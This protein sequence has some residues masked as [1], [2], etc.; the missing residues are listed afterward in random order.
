M[1][2]A[3]PEETLAE[4]YRWFARLEVHGKSPL[5]EELCEGVADDP[6]ML[7]FLA[8][9][10][11]AKRQPNL[12]LATARV[13]F[14]LASDYAG[15]RAAV[16]EHRD[17]VAAMLRTRRTQTN[18]PGRCA[19][20]LPLL[21]ELPQPL[22]LLEV[23]AAAG[24]CLLVDRYGYDYDGQRVGDDEVVF[25]CSVHGDVAVPRRLPEVVW[26]CGIDLEPI[27]LDDADAIG[28]LEALVWPEETDR[29]ERLRRAIT[30]ARRERPRVVRANL[31]D[32]LGIV[33]SEAPP[34][35]TLVVF[36][37][38][39]LSYLSADQRDR[40]R[41]DV[42]GLDAQWISN[43]GPGVVPSL[44]APPLTPVADSHFVIARNGRPVAFCDP[45]G[46]WIQWLPDT[47]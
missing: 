14:G 7:E 41:A 9:Q 28:W 4:N 6:Q 18:E 42:S 17:E 32:A 11:P 30:I 24:L 26:R 22:A 25:E 27:G 46:R 31:L 1:L 44:D 16:L 33:A 21:C 37:T 38:A 36:H 10:P 34:G 29:L 15:F 43:E 3:D 5:Y 47:Q 45:H 35:A 13:L 8:G 19:A 12:L 40:F 2:G 39:V 23:G 20:L